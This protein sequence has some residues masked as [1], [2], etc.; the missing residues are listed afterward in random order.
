MGK[1]IKIKNL[2]LTFTDLISQETFFG[3][4]SMA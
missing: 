1:K 3:A 4:P 2:L